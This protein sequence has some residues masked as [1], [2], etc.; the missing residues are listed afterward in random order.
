MQDVYKGDM[1]LATK[2]R[3]G[4]GKYIYSNKYFT[5]EGDWV[6]G[7]KHGNGKFTLGD[8]TVYEGQFNE[9][10]MTGSGVKTWTDG[11]KYTGQFRN[12]EFEGKGSLQYSSGNIY[13]G[14]FANNLR[15]GMGSFSFKIGDKACC[16]NGEFSNDE[17]HGSGELNIS[18]YVYKGLFQHGKAHDDNGQFL[19]KDK[20]KYIGSC[21]AGLKNGQGVMHY[22]SGIIFKGN[23]ANDKP[24]DP[25]NRY[26]VE[27]ITEFSIAT[28]P[29]PENTDSKKKSK[30]KPPK[31]ATEANTFNIG[32]LIPKIIVLTK[33][34]KIL[35]PQK[36]RP[37]TA[38][39]DEQKKDKKSA[40]K[41]KKDSG[42]DPEEEK[43]YLP[44]TVYSLVQESNRELKL[45]MYKLQ[46]KKKK[47]GEIEEELSTLPEDAA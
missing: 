20:S 15:N 11:T 32:S 34:E 17:F 18:E 19:F 4:Y 16:Y 45:S 44:S 47:K 2:K 24:T 3:H 37:E 41:S 39:E 31:K 23:Y 13:N 7:V 22:A 5:Y 36:K 46:D 35:P 28:L 10:E 9:G 21:K 40:K 29:E 33:S 6:Q 14:L 8:N 38:P 1:D 25:P 43:L 26:F 12:G 30:V 42:V 27:N